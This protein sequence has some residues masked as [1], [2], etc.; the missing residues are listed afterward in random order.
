VEV[1]I[2]REKEVCGF[3]ICLL[4]GMC[5]T[6]EPFKRN[7]V[8]WC[9]DIH[10]PSTITHVY[11]ALLVCYFPTKPI[12]TQI[13]YFCDQGLLELSSRMVGELEVSQFYDLRL[14]LK[15]C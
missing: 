1:D 2:D 12:S 14:G 8:S 10:Y 3:V 5:V 7:D 6:M 15:L 13:I 9:C 4:K 11:H